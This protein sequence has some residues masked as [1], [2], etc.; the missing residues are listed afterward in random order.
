MRISV[1]SLQERRSVQRLFF[2]SL[3]T[4]PARAL[5][6]DAV[7]PELLLERLYA[8][9][10][11]RNLK[12]TEK[13]FEQ[14]LRTP[15]VDRA[16]VYTAAISIYRRY[17]DWKRAVALMARMEVEGTGPTLAT[18]NAAIAAC[19]NRNA[20]KSAKR[21]LTEMPEKG[22]TPDARTYNAAIIAYGKGGQRK[23]AMEIF[24]ALPAKGVTPDV[25]S[26]NAAI[27]LCCNRTHLEPAVALWKEMHEKGVTPNAAIYTR[28][29]K[30]YGLN[31]EGSKM[32]DMVCGLLREMQAAGIAPKKATY[33][34]VQLVYRMLGEPADKP[35]KILDEM[36]AR[37]TT[38]S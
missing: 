8:T 31:F 36:T 10:H 19:A 38:T 24:K 9:R 32:S 3:S 20:W 13:L 27:E 4:N 33:K 25:F 6:D 15:G 16:A 2:A 22:I 7:N 5:R 11:Q 1:S 30:I 37:N 12:L 17:G 35:L 34:A 18:Y 26:Y 23:E 29:I 28:M 21:F 14:G